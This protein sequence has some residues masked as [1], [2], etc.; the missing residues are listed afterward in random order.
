MKVELIFLNSQSQRDNYV[1]RTSP[2]LCLSTSQNHF[3]REKKELHYQV[4]VDLKPSYLTVTNSR[5]TEYPRLS[6]CF[7]TCIPSGSLY[8]HFDK[9]D[10]DGGSTAIANTPSRSPLRVECLLFSLRALL[11]GLT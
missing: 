8:F 5:P 11:I 2:L 9:T 3:P 4:Y 7:A 10:T 6:Y 1:V